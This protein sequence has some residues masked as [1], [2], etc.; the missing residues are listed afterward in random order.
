[1]VL[2]FEIIMIP[3]QTVRGVCPVLEDSPSGPDGRSSDF[4]IDTETDRLICSTFGSERGG[5]LRDTTGGTDKPGTFPPENRFSWSASWNTVMGMRRHVQQPS[6][7][8]PSLGVSHP[9]LK[10]SSLRDEN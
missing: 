4:V 3:L 6:G 5:R 9:L 1:M 10:P 7:H 8:C 2:G